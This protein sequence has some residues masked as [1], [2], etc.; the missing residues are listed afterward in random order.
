MKNI[1]LVF[2]FALLSSTAIG[3]KFNLSGEWKLNEDKSELG[4]EFSLA[5]KAMTVVHTKKTLDQTIVSEWDGV[6]YESK[7]H[8]TLDG[9][10]CENTGF[11]DA[12]TKSTAIYDKK[13]KTIK[14][15]TTGTV[16]GMD[17]TLTQVYS[18]KDGDMII[19]SEAASD[20]GEMFETFVYEKQ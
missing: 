20:M 5:P 18:L 14:I 7:Q 12:V 1:V 2:A 8:F 13:A 3:Q 6:D 4:Y 11:E 17:Y 10:V 16:Q 19:E 9:K 15:V